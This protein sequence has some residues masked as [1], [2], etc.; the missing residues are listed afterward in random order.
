VNT[1]LLSWGMLFAFTAAAVPSYARSTTGYGS[2]KVGN[3]GAYPEDPYTCL[4]ENWGAVVNS[5]TFAVNLVFELPVDDEG[6]GWFDNNQ[7]PVSVQAYWGSTA[8]FS[9]SEYFY[10]SSG[11]W[12]EYF[13]SYS[14]S[15]FSGDPTTGYNTS[16]YIP[17]SNAGGALQ[18]GAIELICPAVPPGAGIANINWDGT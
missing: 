7:F 11:G 1:R 2:F 6:G 14:E 16:F 17:I 10:N 12:N 8:T 15:F 3:E 5:C 13:N 4:T 9:C 18:Q